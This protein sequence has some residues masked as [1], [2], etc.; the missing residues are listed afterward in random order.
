MR[1][2]DFHDL[3]HLIQ[4]LWRYLIT[5]YDEQIDLRLLFTAKEKVYH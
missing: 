5:L 1:H 3:S 2:Y 4:I